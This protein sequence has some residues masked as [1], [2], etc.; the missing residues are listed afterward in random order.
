MYTAHYIEA[1]RYCIQNGYVP[2]RKK[3]TVTE[4]VGRV[5]KSL[6][7]SHPNCSTTSDEARLIAPHF[8]SPEN[9]KLALGNT[10]ENPLEL[11]SL[12]S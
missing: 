11:R 9:I 6:V 2:K 1:K 12:V 8:D 7:C 10:E 4:P 3:G 5:E